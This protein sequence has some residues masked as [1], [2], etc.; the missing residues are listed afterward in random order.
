MTAIQ[1]P[2]EKMKALSDENYRLR[3]EVLISTQ[4][5]SALNSRISMLEREL[6]AK[7][8]DLTCIPPIPMT[9]QVANWI[10]DYQVPWE[11]LYCHEC[12]SWMTQLD[13]TFP[14]HI[15]GNTCMCKGGQDG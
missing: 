6:H 8:F 7:S 12:E 9:K 10:N 13:S 3:R 2:T 11:T 15:E 4:R 14:Y 1:L 5:L